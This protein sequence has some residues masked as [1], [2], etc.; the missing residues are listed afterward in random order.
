M[1]FEL[2]LVVIF[3]GR[4]VGVAVLLS[5]EVLLRAELLAHAIG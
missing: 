1:F 2:C 5:L 4:V 3:M